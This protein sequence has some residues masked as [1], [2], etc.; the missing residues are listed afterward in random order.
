[1]RLLP[2]LVAVLCAAQAA[3]AEP[4]TA[5]RPAVVEG[6]ILDRVTRAPVAGA[7]VS[8]EG[9]EATTLSD[10]GGRF[11]LSLPAGTVR[12]RIEA[13]V[14]QTLETT[15]TVAPGAVLEVRY[16]ITPV[17]TGGYETVVTAAPVREEV[18]RRTLER[19]EVTQ[20]PGT[21]GDPFRVIEALP[22]VV[23]IV[24]GVPYYYVRGAPP[25]DTGYFVDGV[26]VPALF[27][28]ALGPSVVHPT[29]VERVDFWTGGAPARYPSYVG[30]LVSATTSELPADRPHLDV[31]LR[32]VDVGAIASMPLQNGRTRA[33]VSGRYS[34]TAALLSLLQEDVFIDYWD[35]Q[36]RL[37]HRLGPRTEATVFAFGSFDRVGS[38]ERDDRD[39][40]VGRSTDFA[41][42]FHRLDGRVDLRLD[43]GRRLQIA[44]GAG[45]EQ[46]LI[47]DGEL[48]AKEVTIGPRAV[49]RT[50]LGP[51]LALGV[52]ADAAYARSSFEVPEST[53][54]DGLE[55]AFVLPARGLGTLGSWAELRARLM[56]GT[57]VT[58][59]ARF[60]AFQANATTHAAL[61]PRIAVRH[62]LTRGLTLT[63][64][65]GLYHQ[66]PAFVIPIP[67]LGNLD[68]DRGL[69]RSI[70]AAHGIEWQLG[71][72]LGV[73]AQVFFH[74][75]ENISDISF[76][77]DGEDE[78]PRMEGNAY[79]LE[80]LV[81]RKLADRLFGW[82][83]YTL[84]RSERSGGSYETADGCGPFAPPT[85]ARGGMVP[86]DADRTHVANAVASYELGRGFRVGARL[87]YRSG[88]PFTRKRCW[89]DTGGETVTG[90]R[91]AERMPDY[92]RLDLRI[93]KRWRYAGWDLDLYFEVMNVTF[94]REVLEME[95]PELGDGT[96]GPPRVPR[97]TVPIVIPTLGLRAVF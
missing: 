13:A 27:H 63:G 45:F 73:E 24:T 18:S 36:L 41:Q 47:A 7:E 16:A 49:F 93:D 77:G 17:L 20:T 39:R 57:V 4:E 64:N 75:Y 85:R 26:R 3:W 37:E 61:D 65:L 56:P 21:M 40:V 48:D 84:S 70:Q 51:D 30:G 2:P 58:T 60:A 59:G 74:R 72:N 91:G 15:E 12:L 38:I 1:V 82:V 66:P 94:S 6:R 83:A 9:L 46:T 81:R 32:L 50:P 8:A 14:Y 52:G 43:G 92:L 89:S 97:E 79:G 33:S 44:T 80:L 34:Y 67:G 90:P 76:E 25:A 11:R 31:D 10:D 5:P 54:S 96:Y 19:V 95:Q 29:L 55:D 71:W 87:H 28:L 42:V 23:P 22:G 69:Q 88:R 68:F 86:S 53:D 62:R 78:F 35:Y